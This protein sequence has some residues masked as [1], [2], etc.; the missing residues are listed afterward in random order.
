MS[1]HSRSLPVW[2]AWMF[3]RYCSGP[4]LPYQG[5]PVWWSETPCG[6]CGVYGK[7]GGAA[8]QASRERTPGGSPASVV[9]DRLMVVGLNVPSQGAFGLKIGADGATGGCD[10]PWAP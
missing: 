9:V 8:P 5:A 3:R 10:G 6:V 2:K 4:G 7:D 1:S